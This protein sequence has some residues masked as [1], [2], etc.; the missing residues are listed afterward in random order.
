MVGRSSREKGIWRCW[1]RSKSYGRRAKRRNFGSLE[2]KGWKAE[3][4]VARVE[5]LA[6]ACPFT[7]HQAVSDDTLEELYGSADCLI[8]APMDEGFG[9]PLIEAPSRGLLLI[10][11]DIP[12]FREACGN[13]AT[14]FF[15]NLPEVLSKWLD[16][17]P[18]GQAKGSKDIKNVSW[19][20][21]TNA[22]MDEVILRGLKVL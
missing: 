21:S 12:D 19:D 13:G 20:E 10:A 16:D 14:Y 1:T 11:R 5:P 17:Y 2:N 3:Q 15:A 9:L 4:I 7:W 18:R 8:A 22:L 6:T